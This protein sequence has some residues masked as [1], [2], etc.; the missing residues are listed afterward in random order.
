M[1]TKSNLIDLYP[2]F[3][4]IFSVT[5]HHHWR[6]PSCK[7]LSRHLNLSTKFRIS[8]WDAD[9][10]SC[11]PKWLQGKARTLSPFAFRTQF[12]YQG[13]KVGII[14]FCQ[15]SVGGNV[16]NQKYV[17]FEIGYSYGRDRHVH[18]LII[19]QPDRKSLFWELL[20]LCRK[21]LGCPSKS[22]NF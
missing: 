18:I 22:W 20:V 9:P 3:Q 12:I 21:Q 1:R 10:G 19:Y 4:L 15:T 14:L 16:V 6:V 7:G 2:V 13:R 5:T 11:T 8:S 17:T